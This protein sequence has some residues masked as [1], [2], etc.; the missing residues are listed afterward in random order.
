MQKNLNSDKLLVNFTSVCFL[1]IY[2]INFNI[3][4]I[5]SPMAILNQ[6]SDICK[7][8]ATK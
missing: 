8:L 5:I 3:L 1:V 4:P 7:P 6:K 2:K